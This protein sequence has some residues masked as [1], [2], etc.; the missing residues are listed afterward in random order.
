MVAVE[1]HVGMFSKL[2]CE[3][4]CVQ[5]MVMPGLLIHAQIHFSYMVQA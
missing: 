2:E 5:G 1:T 3:S 4:E